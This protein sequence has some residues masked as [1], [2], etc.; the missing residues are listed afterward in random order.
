MTVLHFP[1]SRMDIRLA[2]DEARRAARDSTGGAILTLGGEPF[3][4]Q[5]FRALLLA[6]VALIILSVPGSIATVVFAHDNLMGLNHIFNLDAENSVPN[7]A[8]SIYLLVAGTLA[9]VVAGAKQRDGDPFRRHWWGLAAIVTAFS[10]E[11]IADVHGSV[12]L[13]FKHFVPTSGFFYFAWTIPGMIFVAGL[14]LVFFR[15]WRHF[16]PAVRRRFMAATVIYFGSAVGFELLESRIFE[17]GHQT[18]FAYIAFTTIEESGEMLGAALLIRMLLM[19]LA[20]MGVNFRIERP[21]RPA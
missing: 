14:V 16:A 12:G 13:V 1:S 5:V 20:D 15:F 11:E 3:A 21:S 10:V 4:Q 18:G 7:W 8:S 2:A 19:Y 9:G 17:A 6:I